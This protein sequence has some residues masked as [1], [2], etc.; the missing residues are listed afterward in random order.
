MTDLLIIIPAR[1]GSKRLKNKNIIKIGGKELVLKTI[2]FAKKIKA[3]KKII[4]SSDSMK[5]INLVINYDKRIL[6]PGL[7]PKH[8]S[9]DK[10]KTEDVAD[11]IID[12]YENNFNQVSNILLLQPTTPYRDATKFNKIYNIFLKKKYESLISVSPLINLNK[13]II[14]LKNEKIF[15]KKKL[16]E[17]LYQANGSF[18][19]IQKKIFKKYKTFV[20]KNTSVSVI[21]DFNQTIDIDT[22]I[23]LEIAKKFEE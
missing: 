18:Y 22:N 2:D 13:K 12:W 4:I 20:P 15:S 9:S 16:N 23:D 14:T 19:L 10:A 3:K 5:I 1:K 17:N 11:Y 21:K 6:S 8:L 7:R